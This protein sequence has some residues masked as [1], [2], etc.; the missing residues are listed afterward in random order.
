MENVDNHNHQIPTTK[1]KE[2]VKAFSKAEDGTEDGI[3]V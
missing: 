3:E 2:N 1:V